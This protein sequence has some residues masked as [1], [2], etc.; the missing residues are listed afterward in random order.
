MKILIVMAAALASL[1]AQEGNAT[2]ERT[3]PSKLPAARDPIQM[4]TKGTALGNVG[5]S[6]QNPYR[7][8]IQRTIMLGEPRPSYGAILT[9]DDQLTPALSGDSSALEVA[10]DLKKLHAR[11]IFFA[12]VPDN[13]KKNLGR[14]L[15]SKDPEKAALEFLTK[16]KSSFVKT[17]RT[18]LKIKDGDQFVCEI[19]NHTAFHQ[20]MGSMKAGSDRFKV[21][22]VGIRFIEKC[23]DEAYAFERPGANRS[24]YFRF[25]FLH[26]PSDPSTL[27]ELNKIFT[28]LGLLTLG[29][30]Q[31]SKDVLNFS[32]D[33][34]YEALVAA[35]NNQRYNPDLKAHGQTEQPIALFHTRSWSKIKS[36]IIKAISPKKESAQ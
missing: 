25:P 7:R 2:T 36:G 27:V 19:F 14:I 18:L 31:D 24:R 8:L 15:K 30:T 23:L 16:R 1:S 6:P 4:F 13:S 34:A 28:E 33:F 32:P 20:N 5:D 22:M 26:S 12:N 21:C 9:F 11:A 3:L 10:S 35:Q 29:E 17:I